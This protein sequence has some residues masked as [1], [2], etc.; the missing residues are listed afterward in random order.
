M[1][2]DDALL[3]ALRVRI[4]VMETEIEALKGTI[5]GRPAYNWAGLMSEVKTLES[6]QLQLKSMLAAF[7][8]REER[9]DWEKAR[10]ERTQKALLASILAI[11][12]PLA[13]QALSGLLFGG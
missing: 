11:V 9:R 5:H 1:S 6:K 7:E 10:S 2:E 4:D 12:V 8:S 13:V 3:S